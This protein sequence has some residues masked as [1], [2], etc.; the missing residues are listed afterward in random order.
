[1]NFSN[2]EIFIEKL[3][4]CDLSYLLTA[5]SALLSAFGHSLAEV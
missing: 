5:L 3:S 1:M 2:G 4:D